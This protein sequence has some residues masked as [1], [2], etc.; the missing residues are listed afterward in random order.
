MSHYSYYNKENEKSVSDNRAVEFF[1][2]VS[3]LSKLEKT[4]KLEEMISNIKRSEIPLISEYIM[5]NNFY[6]YSLKILS[7]FSYLYPE[8]SELYLEIIASLYNMDEI[9][10]RYN[11]HP[12][13]L[14]L[15]H[16][17]YNIIPKESCFKN[18]VISQFVLKYITKKLSYEFVP[19]ILKKYFKWCQLAESD[20]YI[21]GKLLESGYLENSI[22][23]YIKNDDTIGFLGIVNTLNI[24]VNDSYYNIF[25]NEIL[26]FITLATYFG[27]VNIFKA[28]IS[29][30][31]QPDEK[32]FEYS[33]HSF[34]PEIVNLL[35]VKYNYDYSRCIYLSIKSNKNN[36]VDWILSNYNPTGFNAYQSLAWFNTTSFLYCVENGANIHEV[37]FGGK[38]LLMFAS[39]LDNY[40]VVDYLIKIGCNAT[41]TDYNGYTSYML[42]Y[43]CSNTQSFNIITQYLK[44]NDINVH[45]GNDADVDLKDVRIYSIVC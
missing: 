45:D 6:N 35:N 25:T 32:T 38:T 1:H 23:Y 37:H 4:I 12:L 28:C 42:A 41:L 19:L 20:F 34:V 26:S 16:K 14:F 9:V 3:S 33:F 22:G 13:L 29:L 27:S 40:E 15:I 36:F 39:E 2:C 10:T 24:N 30:G 43:N 17:R 44:D 31:V 11:F 21:I 18:D 7:F 8:N 5:S